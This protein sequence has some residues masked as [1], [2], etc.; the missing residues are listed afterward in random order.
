V[1]DATIVSILPFEYIPKFPGL[2]PSSY[3]I[4]AAPEND[5]VVVHIPDGKGFVDI[6]EGRPP[7]IQNHSGEQIA[8]SIANDLIS[9]SMYTTD[10]AFPGIKA[11]PGRHEKEDIEKNFPDLLKGMQSA[12]KLWFGEW[13]KA[14]DNIWSD[15]NARGKAYSISDMHRISANRLGLNREWMTFTRTDQYR[16]PACTNFIPES[17]LICPLCKTIVKPKE[18]AD[19]FQR[20]G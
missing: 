12:Q 8:G 17:A 1:S 9:S 14:A 18:Y 7:L 16:C 19:K 10:I 15:P 4:P 3:V 6:H 13:V 2:V 11:L 20:V 5:F